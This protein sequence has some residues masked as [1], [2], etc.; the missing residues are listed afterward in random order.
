[1]LRIEFRRER[2]GAIQFH[3][4]QSVLF[5]LLTHDASHSGEI[6]Q[7]L[8]SHGQGEIDLWSGLARVVPAAT[9][10]DG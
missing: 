5:R 4:R 2:G 6:S 3:T 7:T 8:G 1:M 10:E 9:A